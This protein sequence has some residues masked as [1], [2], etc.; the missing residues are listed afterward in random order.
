MGLA[1]VGTDGGGVPP[2][3]SPVYDISVDLDI[4]EVYARWATL[5]SRFEFYVARATEWQNAF[6][7]SDGTTDSKP[8]TYTVTSSWARYSLIRTASGKLWRYIEF[9]FGMNKSGI[10]GLARSASYQGIGAAFLPM[11]VRHAYNADEPVLLH[12]TASTPTG[13][14]YGEQPLIEAVAP[15]PRGLYQRATEWLTR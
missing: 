11:T 6:D 5:T 15:S 8:A 9:Q 10:I 2:P 7:Q 14:A 3:G 4:V 13:E 1:A 12:W